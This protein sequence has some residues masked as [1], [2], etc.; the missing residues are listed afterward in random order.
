M[1]ITLYYTLYVPP[2]G[3]GEILGDVL[4]QVGG[5]PGD[6]SSCNVQYISPGAHK[7]LISQTWGSDLAELTFWTPTMTVPLVVVVLLAFVLEG[8]HI[9]IL[10][11]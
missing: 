11:W 4:N 6:V 2:Q 1:V 5:V 8:K 9:N 10:V 3:L 7:L